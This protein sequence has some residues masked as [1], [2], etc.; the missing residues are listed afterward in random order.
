MLGTAALLWNLWK[1]RNSACFQ[2]KM[3]NNPTNVIFSMFRLLDDWNILQKEKVRRTVPRVSERMMNCK[4]SFW[5]E[6]R[7]GSCDKKNL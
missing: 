4:R 7:M 3:P 2:T 1:T 6:T 5:E